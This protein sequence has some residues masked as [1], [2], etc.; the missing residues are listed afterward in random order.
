ML[1]LCVYMFLH[2]CSRLDQWVSYN[3]VILSTLELP[4]VSRESVADKISATDAVEKEPSSGRISRRRS[5]VDGV[6]D[7]TKH[8]SSDHHHHDDNDFSFTGGNWHASGS[9]SGDPAAAAFEKEHEETTKVKNIEK[10]VMGSFQ[11]DAWYFRCVT[12]MHLL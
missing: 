11:V 10:I 7:G 1:L 3:K 12:F 6:S 8:V 5:S 9:T 4:T 2:I